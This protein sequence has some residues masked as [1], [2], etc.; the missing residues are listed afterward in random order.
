MDIQEAFAKLRQAM[1]TMTEYV[2]IEDPSEE[3]RATLRLATVDA[4]E[5]W[6]AVDG[7]LARG[8]YLPYRWAANR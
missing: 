3:Q 4:T 6:E 7:W 1:L 5:A 8:G 2:E